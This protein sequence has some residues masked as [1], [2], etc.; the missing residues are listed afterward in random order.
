MKKYCV[1]TFFFL[2]I[3]MS[4]GQAQI[5]VIPQFGINSSVFLHEMQATTP[6]LI[7]PESVK[8]M[9]IGVD[10]Q[11]PISGRL[12]LEPGV[13]LYRIGGDVLLVDE[14]ISVLPSEYR[15][16]TNYLKV[17]ISVGYFLLYNETLKVRGSMGLVSS[18]FTGI[19]PTP[20]N[21]QNDDFANM[22]VGGLLGIG[23][24]NKINNNSHITFDFMYELGLVSILAEQTGARNRI[25]SF[26]VGLKM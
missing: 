24:D 15:V 19:R 20:S 3:S 9:Q 22:L 16:E 11:I 4:N 25:L 18:L 8:N 12:F 6:S 7:G 26:T 21:I 2:F 10:L 23:F 13:F 14:E 5:S 1:L 17:P